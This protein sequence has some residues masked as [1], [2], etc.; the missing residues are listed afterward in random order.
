MAIDSDVNGHGK[1][2]QQKEEK[3]LPR[4]ESEAARLELVD[5]VRLATEELYQLMTCASE[6]H[7]GAEDVIQIKI[8][9]TMQTLQHVQD[10]STQPELSQLVP[11]KVMAMVDQGRNPDIHT[12]NF[13]NRLVGDNQQLRGQLESFD[14]YRDTLREKLAHAFPEMVPDLESIDAR[15]LPAEE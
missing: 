10:A 8:N 2:Q 5:R 4:P 9:E 12:R 6:I 1:Q 15:A 3:L 7:E 11:D 13:V 14:L